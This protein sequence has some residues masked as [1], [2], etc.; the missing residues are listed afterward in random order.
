MVQ[1]R[2]HNMKIKQEAQSR[3]D[4]IEI[5]IP[6][7]K[8]FVKHFN[9]IYQENM[10]KY[11]PNNDRIH[12]WVSEMQSHYNFVRELKLSYNK[13]YLNEKQMFNWFAEA[14]ST[15]D[16]WFPNK[17]KKEYNIYKK[18]FYD[19]LKTNDVYI[20]LDKLGLYSIDEWESK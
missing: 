12:H 2:N 7:G 6:H 3:A 5:V 8:E 18:F 11:N 1:A 14:G 16:E 13:K 20:S 17:D 9:K 19:L 15:A 10:I 4:T